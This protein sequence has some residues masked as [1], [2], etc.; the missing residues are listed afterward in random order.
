MLSKSKK[1]KHHYSI[2]L[3][4]FLSSRQEIEVG[5]AS[6]ISQ[7]WQKRP[8]RRHWDRWPEVQ[9]VR[10]LDGPMSRWSDLWIFWW[11][12]VRMVRWPDGLMFKWSDVRTV[13]CPEDQMVRGPNWSDVLMIRCLDGLMVRCMDGQMS[14]WSNV[15]MVRCLDG[16][17][18][19]RW[20]VVQIARYLDVFKY[21]KVYKKNPEILL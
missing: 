6:K 8:F 5:V 7:K 12:N 9:L 14:R 19:S 15:Q 1:V 2:F 20:P 4:D 11:P 18:L 21:I 16:Q 17:M 13:R 10:C 3:W